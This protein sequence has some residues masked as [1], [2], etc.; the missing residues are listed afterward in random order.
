MGNLLLA[1]HAPGQRGI[2]PQLLQ[3]IAPHLIAA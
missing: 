3:L 2:H 1:S